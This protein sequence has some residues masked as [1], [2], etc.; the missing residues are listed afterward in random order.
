MG[1]KF[2]S[3]NKNR[4][5]VLKGSYSLSDGFTNTQLTLVCHSFRGIRTAATRRW[6]LDLEA[7]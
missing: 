6:G 4:C 2:V 3:G 1:G 5:L 7:F